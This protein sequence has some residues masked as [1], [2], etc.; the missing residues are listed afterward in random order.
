SKCLGIYTPY[1]MRGV[2]LC[3]VTQKL[4][5]LG[6]K[7]RTH[8][9]FVLRASLCGVLRELIAESTGV[10]DPVL[11]FSFGNSPR[12]TKLAI[13]VMNANGTLLGFIKVPLSRCAARRVRAEALML[14][15]LRDI[16]SIRCSVPDV[17]FSGER[18]GVS[19][20]FESPCEGKPAGGE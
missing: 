10:A 1:G 15:R 17:L 14:K 5:R 12:F 7:G 19:V 8:D 6:W 18:D 2:A 20:L 13:Q 16:A 4:L 3:A 11:S 9:R